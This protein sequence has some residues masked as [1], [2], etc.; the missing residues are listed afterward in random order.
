MAF[1]VVVFISSRSP[2][3]FGT[4]LSLLDGRPSILKTILEDATV[5]FLVIFGAHLLS[6]VVALVTRVSSDI[7]V[8]IWKVGNQ[9]A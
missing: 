4:T 5:Y 9:L 8:I 6:L 1:S 3:S 7:L 2:L